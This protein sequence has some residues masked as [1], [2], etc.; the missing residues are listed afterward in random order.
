MYILGSPPRVRGKVKPAT[1]RDSIIRITPA[2]AGKSPLPFLLQ[3][4]RQD[5]PRVCGEKKSK[6]PEKSVQMG[7][8]PRVRGKVA[9]LTFF[10]LFSGITPAC[11]GKSWA[12]PF[13]HE[14]PGDHPR[15]CGE[16]ASGLEGYRST[17]GSPPRVRGKVLR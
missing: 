16:K 2:C 10:R 13:L 1:Q 9:T 3:S 14:Y 7:S 17:L 6:I 12:T 11:A 5:H 8:P 15:V 4:R